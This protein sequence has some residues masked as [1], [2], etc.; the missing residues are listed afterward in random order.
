MS[1]VFQFRRRLLKGSV[2]AIA[3]PTFLATRPTLAADYPDGQPVRIVAPTTPGGSA[4]TVARLLSTHMGTQIGV[5]CVVENI[6]GAGGTVGAARVARAKADGH[7][8]LLGFTSNIGTAPLVRSLPYDP[9][10]DFAPLPDSP[11]VKED[12]TWSSIQ[13][14]LP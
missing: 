12:K 7:T 14:S 9:T 5:P 3:L 13:P 11:T 1:R 8:L 2:G 4:D 10:R 6:T